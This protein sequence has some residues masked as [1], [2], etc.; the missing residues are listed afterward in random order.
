MNKV[1]PDHRAWVTLEEARS[2]FSG[3][4]KSYAFGDTDE[5]GKQSIAAFAALTKSRVEF[6]PAENRVYFRR[7]GPAEASVSNVSGAR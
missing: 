2:L 4:D 1:L 7:L 5:A 3:A 6:M